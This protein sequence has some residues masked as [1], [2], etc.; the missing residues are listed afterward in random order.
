MLTIQDRLSIQV[1]L[2]GKE[3]PFRRVNSLDYLHMVASAK[4]AV[5]MV[6]LQLLD[7]VGWLTQNNVLFDGSLIE[8]VVSN[9]NGGSE[10]YAFRMNSYKEKR[11]GDLS[12]VRIDGYLNVPKYWGGSQLTPEI[13]TPS[14]ALKTIA[15]TCGMAADVDSTSNSQTWFARN[16]KYHTWAREI[17]DA[18][19]AGDQSCLMLAIDFNN[20]LRYKNIGSSEGT[21]KTLSLIQPVRDAIYV[22]IFTPRVAPGVSN[23]ES[24]YQSYMVQQDPLNAS[25]YRVHQRVEF[26]NDENGSLMVNGEIRSGIDRSKVAFAPISPGNVNETFER[27]RYQ[28]RRVGFLFSV[29]L[30][31]VTPDTTALPLLSAVNVV[32]PSDER[33]RYYSGKYRVVSR[34]I[35]VKGADYYEKL[36]LSRKTLNAPPQSAVVTAEGSLYEDFEG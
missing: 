36:E 12:T 2:N 30:D 22:P 13:G 26:Q 11:S 16:Q 14:E 31:V 19:Y 27:G 28:N 6:D 23:N 8:I 20:S 1:M 15:A 32:A 34:V 7:S 25:L 24:G 18:G 33:T 3:F 9:K 4:L 17:A 10:A 35:Y 5:P 21:V 29:G